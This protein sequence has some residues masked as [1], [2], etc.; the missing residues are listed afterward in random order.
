MIYIQ[1]DSNDPYFNHALE[2]YVMREI[3][4][5]VFILWRNR[6]S[7][8]IG[9]NQNT[10]SEINMDYVN[11]KKID[12]VRRPS[13]GGT[14][15]CDLGNINFS[16]IIRKGQTSNL[17]RDHRMGVESGN[18]VET[19]ISGTL[20]CCGFEKFAMPVVSALKALGI[21]AVFSGRNDILVEGAKISGNAQYHEG[22]K[23]LHH[24]TLLYDGDLSLLIGA[25]KS[26]PLKFKDKSVKSVASR[27][28]NIANHMTEKMDVLAFREYL[29]TF[30]MKDHDIEKVYQL[31]E[32][33][34]QSIAKIQKEKFESYDWNFGKSPS[35]T[36]NNEVRF[37]AGTFEFQAK[38]KGGNI[39]ALK[40]NGDFFGEEPMENLCEKLLG[41]P[42]ELKAL[43]KEL[44]AIDLQP[45]AQNLKKEE[46]LSGLMDL[47]K[48]KPDW[49]K[50]KLQ[51]GRETE[52]VK[53]I[54]SELSLNTVCQEANCPNRMECYNKG[55]ATFMIL[56]RNCTRNCT[57]CNVSRALPDPVDGDEPE[58]VALAVEK[59]GL[60]HTV[61][62]SVTRDDLED[63]GAEHF[64]KTVKAIRAKTPQ[65]VIELL[66]PDLSGREDLLDMVIDSQPDVLNHNVETVPELYG[67][68]RPMAN[69]ERSLGVL[70]YFK[71]KAPHIKTKSGIMLGLGETMPQ[72]EETLKALR[73]VDCDMLTVGQYL[74]PSPE[75]IGVVEYIRPEQFEAIRK[76][77]ETLGFKS[78]AS[79]PLVRSSYHADEM[80]Y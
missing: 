36:F 10:L 23:L 12:V 6:P 8:L 80:N 25:L 46:F 52:K 77:A 58:K 79:A 64:A 7:I 54:L 70:A 40:I 27:V 78:V 29:R 4:E 47:K 3:D 45:Y 39:E 69:F 72:I 5:D 9:R 71:K 67:T 37:P 42:F 44:A 49:L 60:K 26:K 66:I 53:V 31:T 30:I 24:G 56:G 59:L 38:V 11:E 61:I 28:T 57:F 34:L 19:T 16:F 50:V 15:F 63:Q 62:T 18:S 17:D 41:K 43:Q 14:V 1:N 75:H 51:G 20:G 35:Y 13:G 2:L 74:Q 32:E 33:D 76:M 22:N 48:S 55:T 73:R 68:V 65:V 21:E